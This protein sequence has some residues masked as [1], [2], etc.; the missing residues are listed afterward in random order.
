MGNEVKF[1]LKGDVT[2]GGREFMSTDAFAEQTGIAKK[3]LEIH[4]SKGKGCRFYKIAGKALYAVD[5]GQAFLESLC[6][7]TAV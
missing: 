5:D 1:K 6:V 3:T 4:R 2:I 7:E